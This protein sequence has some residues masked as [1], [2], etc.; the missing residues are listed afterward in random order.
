MGEKHKASIE[1]R[2]AVSGVLG[3]SIHYGDAAGGVTQGLLLWYS[4]VTLRDY[5]NRDYAL[6]YIRNLRDKKIS[7]TVILWPRPIIMMI[8]GEQP[9]EEVLKTGSG[10]LLLA[11][12]IENAEVD[13]LK[14]RRLCQTLF[15][16]ACM[17]RNNGDETACMEKMWACFRLENP[18]LELE[19]YLARVECVIE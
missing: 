13:L 1:W 9:F 7:S 16:S 3:E 6:K 11:E 5:N 15:Y 10:S 2:G 8:L 17:D 18:I 19:W 14:R 12:C 4:A